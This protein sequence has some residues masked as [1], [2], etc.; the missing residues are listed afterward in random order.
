MDSM[1]TR[2]F[3]A[4]PVWLPTFA[5]A[6]LGIGLGGITEPAPLVGIAS[7]AVLGVAWALWHLDKAVQDAG[8]AVEAQVIVPAIPEPAAAALEAELSQKLTAWQGDVARMEDLLNLL[9][10]NATIEA[11]R[12]GDAGKGFAVVAN[13]IKELARETSMAT[14][15][16][17][18][19]I[20]KIQSEAAA[21]VDAIGQI[22]Q[23]VSKISE[24]QNMIA[25][26]V[27]E[28]TATASEMAQNVNEAARG[29]TDIARSIS[30]VAQAAQNIAETATRTQE[31]ANSLVATASDI[32]NATR[33][34]LNE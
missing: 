1:G 14:E 11:A 20:K 12:V 5:V 23:I 21:A 6:G 10:L 22:G 29:S 3:G 9:A 4:I 7:A 32:R 18:K 33:A 15:N 19:Q 8:R 28:Q 27:E 2:I 25:A 13:E 31:D 17:G 30:G 26:A 16:I 24:S 34:L